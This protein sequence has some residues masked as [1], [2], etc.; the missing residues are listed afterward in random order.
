[1][2]LIVFPSLERNIK[3]WPMEESGGRRHVRQ[4]GFET[5]GF[6]DGLGEPAC[7]SIPQRDREIDCSYIH[8]WDTFLTYLVVGTKRYDS[9]MNHEQ[10]QPC[11]KTV[12][13][14]HQDS[15]F[16]TAGRAVPQKNWQLNLLQ[17]QSDPINLN[18]G[19]QKYPALHL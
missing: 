4:R 1:M 14:L 15:L 2:C 9:C 5:L 7:L 17:H 13:Q 12:S 18:S 6:L 19:Q 10:L 16:R 11:D 3:R 8:N